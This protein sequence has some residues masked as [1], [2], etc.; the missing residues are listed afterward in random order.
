VYDQTKKQVYDKSPLYWEALRH[1]PIENIRAALNAHVRDP[2]RGRFF[3][4]PADIEAQLPSRELW[5]DAEEAWAMCPKDEHAS[6]AMTDE[7]AQA[8]G[9]ALD[10][11]RDGDMI[12]A[13]MAFKS[14]YTRLVDEAKRAGKAPR[15]FAS[16]GHDK[17]GRY[18]AECKVV[19]MHNRLLPPE[20][21][22]ALPAPPD[23][24]I[25]MNQLLLAA[26]ENACSP[27][28][29]K[30]HLAALKGML[31]VHGGGV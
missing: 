24:A 23:D 4:K 13:R 5:H 30:E 3:P 2:D 19:E 29:A 17:Q 31:G 12:A 22:R 18:E 20:Q 25:S 8:L 7:M 27:E 16:L 26:P 15:W 6:A 21:H 14:A 28:R 11:I 10:L 9:V 1:H